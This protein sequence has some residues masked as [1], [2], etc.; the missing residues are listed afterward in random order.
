MTEP[1]TTAKPV[2]MKAGSPGNFQTDPIALHPL[3]QYLDRSSLIWECAT[4]N[5]NLT[6]ELRARGYKV[7]DTDILSG[8]DF[9]TW[10][11]PQWNVIVTNP[12]YPLKQEF[13]ERAYSLGKPFAF[14]MPITTLET[15]KRQRLFHRFGVEVVL[16]DRRI[17][18]ET[19]FGVNG[20][21]W[22]GSAWFTRGLN[23]GSQLTFFS[24]KRYHL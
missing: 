13:L 22:F 5:G 9:L 7:I 11:P 14:L 4:G 12:P 18:F 21:A 15:Y 16:M 1:H 2:S 19:P 10:Q 6:N 3:Y 23:I 24:Y 17:N 8:F 20:K